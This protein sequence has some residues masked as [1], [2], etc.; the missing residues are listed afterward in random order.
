[1]YIIGRVFITHGQ[2]YSI[3]VQ[4][5]LSNC[6]IIILGSIIYLLKLGGAFHSPTKTYK[7]A[8]PCLGHSN[9]HH[10]LNYFGLDYQMGIANG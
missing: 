2:N 9:K 5:P 3:H 7:Q 10:K 4:I 8:I 1:V 6:P